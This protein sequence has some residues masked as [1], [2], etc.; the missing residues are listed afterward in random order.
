MTRE[1]E[2]VDTDTSIAYVA[3]KMR[4]HGIGIVPV[5]DGETLVGTI[6]TDARSKKRL[7]S[8]RIFALTVYRLPTKCI[9]AEMP[10]DFLVAAER[11]AFHSNDVGKSLTGVFRKTV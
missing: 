10:L 11:S 2:L 1:V 3:K 5:C 7:V 4:A 6:A 9:P 8:A